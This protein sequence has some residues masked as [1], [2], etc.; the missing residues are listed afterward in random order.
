MVA[1][2][3]N[4]TIIEAARAMIFD[5]NLEYYLWVEASCTT[6]YIQNSNPH[7]Y[8]RDKTPEEIFTKVKP[9]IS[10]LISHLRICGCPVYI[11]VPEEKRTKLQLSGRKDIFVGY[12]ETSKA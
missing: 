9:N 2:K 11:H 5:Q 10:H 7:S 8:L 4:R 1:E 6:I 12:S 3:K